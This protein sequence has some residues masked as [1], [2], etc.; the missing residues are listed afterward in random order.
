[1]LCFTQ[2]LVTQLCLTLCDSMDCSLPGSSVHSDS[3]GKNTGMGC[4]AFFQGI[5][6]IQGSN[7]SLPYY[8][9]D[10]L[11]SEPPGKRKLS[12][13]AQTSAGN[14]FSPILSPAFPFN[15]APNSSYL[16]C[17]THLLLFLQTASN[18]L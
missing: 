10:S 14:L 3:P 7:P 1:M 9:W 11:L 17:H 13:Y 18:F 6:P 16:S 4:H 8:R 15:F 2:C 5:F 12:N